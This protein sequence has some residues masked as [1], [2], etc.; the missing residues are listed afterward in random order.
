MTPRCVCGAFGLACRGLRHGRSRPSCRYEMASKDADKEGDCASCLVQF[1]STRPSRCY[2]FFSASSFFA[3]LSS[4]HLPPSPV[5]LSF[6][7]CHSF[8]P[9]FSCSALVHHPQG[10]L[11]FST[12]GSPVHRQQLPP[13]RSSPPSRRGPNPV[14]Y[15]IHQKKRLPG[16]CALSHV[17]LLLCSSSPTS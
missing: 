1:A 8:H 3:H 7:R 6:I 11:P 5:T 15:C 16:G 4:R 17:I 10:L 14:V 12:L 13:P 9:F 2:S